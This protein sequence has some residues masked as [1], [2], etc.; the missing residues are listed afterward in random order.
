MIRHTGIADS[1]EKNGII[2]AQSLNA[3][4]RHHLMFF[5][6]IGAA[7]GE[8][9]KGKAEG[10]VLFRDTPENL[11]AFSGD[12]RSDPVARDDGNFVSFHFFPPCID[13]C[14]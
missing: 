12:F 11:D 3:V 5:Q 8:S 2:M 9:V 13:S 7:P 4:V 14:V 1:A 10:A 6:I